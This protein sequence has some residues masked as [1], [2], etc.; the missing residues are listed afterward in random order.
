MGVLE[1][2]AKR[3][4]AGAGMADAIRVA[5][6]LDSMGIKSVI[7]FLGEDVLDK[8]GA[9]SAVLEYKGLIKAIG[10]SG[11]GA[12]IS[13][14]LTNLGLGI[15]EAVARE[16]A[17]AVIR[18]ADD[19]GCRAR[20]DMEGSL[21][22][23]KTIDAFLGIHEGHKNSGIAVQSYLYRSEKD[24]RLLMAKGASI[25]LVKGA[26]K[27]P[28]DVAFKDKKDTDAN[29]ERLMYELLL[30]G[31]LPAIA[32][33]DEALIK[34]AVSFAESNGISKDNFEF[35]MLLGIKRGLQKS[36]ARDGFRVR[37]YVPYGRDWLPYTLR[38][39][40]ERKENL[41]FVLR[42]ILD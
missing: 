12:S 38:R 22:T 20:I 23:Q 27:E 6:S 24:V 41:Y 40:G 34:K 8:K 35:E 7:S 15:G 17:E 26:Y 4:I 36:L 39:L 33:H 10:E 16:N 5:S 37:V 31:N 30:N 14:K 28:P 42:N 18:E 11:T 29:Y 9:D 1:F 19:H 13:I 25:R 21:Y 3:Y 32:T 2:F